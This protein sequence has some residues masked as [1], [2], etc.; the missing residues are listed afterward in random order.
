MLILLYFCGM[1][2]YPFFIVELHDLE[3]SVPFVHFQEIR[4]DVRKYLMT[5][6]SRG[7]CP[8]NKLGSIGL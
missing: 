5:C 6:F 7:S 3:E 8:K 4:K 2:F 1:L